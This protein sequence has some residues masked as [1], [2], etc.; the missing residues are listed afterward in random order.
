MKASTTT[1]RRGGSGL[2]GLA[3]PSR[4][5]TS[6]SL[7]D[8]DMRLL[9]HEYRYRTRSRASL[10]DPFAHS[11][12]DTGGVLPRTHYRSGVCKSQRAGGSGQSPYAVDMSICGAADL[13]ERTATA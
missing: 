3:A 9:W 11:A 10:P 12:G 5:S 4:S 6:A 13:L 8:V 1:L 2:Y 7:K